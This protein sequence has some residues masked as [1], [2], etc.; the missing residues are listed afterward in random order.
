LTP[1]EKESMKMCLMQS[2]FTLDVLKKQEAFE[3][4]IDGIPKIEVVIKEDEKHK[5]LNKVIK[6][7]KN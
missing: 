7:F 1:E 6:W 4:E 3:L 5:K 2:Q